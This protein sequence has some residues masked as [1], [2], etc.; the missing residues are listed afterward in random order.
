MYELIDKVCQKTGLPTWWVDGIYINNLMEDKKSE[1]ELIEDVLYKRA[2]I[3]NYKLIHNIDESVFDKRYIL[4][5]VLVDKC[6]LSDE[7][8]NI[9]VK[10][11]ANTLYFAHKEKYLNV[12]V[13]QNLLKAYVQIHQNGKFYQWSVMECIKECEKIAGFPF[14]KEI[15]ELQIRYNKIICNPNSAIDDK[16]KYIEW[17]N[18]V[19]KSLTNSLFDVHLSK[20]D[21]FKVNGKLTELEPVEP[22]EY[23]ELF[24]REEIVETKADIVAVYYKVAMENLSMIRET[25][26]TLT[27]EIE[28]EGK[29][30]GITMAI[31]AIEGTVNKL[32]D[33]KN[34][35][36]YRTI[37]DINLSKRVKVLVDILEINNIDKK[38]IDKIIEIIDNLLVIQKGLMEDTHKVS[39]VI[40]RGNKIRTWLNEVL[41]SNCV[42]NLEETLPLILKYLYRVTKIEYPGFLGI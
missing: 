8:D 25:N 16:N 35:N 23:E 37:Q 17:Y 7:F 21:D 2:I 36:L 31:K 14:T 26:I 1:D 5:D 38:E 10:G 18:C 24:F 40:I 3:S 39:E 4:K 15:N 34:S 42:R 30:I 29:I 41:D 6:Q 11:E 22:A 9:L 12:N 20:M 19:K 13:P 28:Y 33:I 27:K 32:L